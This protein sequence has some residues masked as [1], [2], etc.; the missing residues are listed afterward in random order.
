M[1]FSEPLFT[2]DQEKKRD[3]RLRLAL[4]VGV[5]DGVHAGHR[6]II[7]SSRS[8]AGRNSALVCAVT[9]DP[10]PKSLFGEAPQLLVT[11]D[12]RRRLL[13]D[14][15][16]DM[17][18]TINFTAQTAALP[19]EEFLFRL[20]SDPAF[21]LSGLCVGEHWR[22]GSR[23]R[24]NKELIKEFAS[25]YGFEFC[26]V[27]ELNDGSDIISSTLIRRLIEQGNLPRAEKLLGSRIRLCGKVV[28]GFGVAGREL[29]TPTANLDVEYGVVPPNGV[30]ACFAEIDGV[31]HPAA[32][33]IGVAPTYAVGKCRVEVHL[34]DSQA[35]LYG[36]KIG[37]EICKFIRCEQK[38]PDPGALKKQIMTDIRE[39]GAVLT[40]LR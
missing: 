15:G 8:I 32:V 1:Q 26:A 13:L 29:E 33:N 39:I 16:A 11:P 3:E 20:I 6:K 31:I 17:T 27:P 37:L 12:R 30:Y 40:A 34:L 38:F 23:G 4:A 14:A 36:R 21:E 19:P 2:F 9:F 7:E 18:A 24:G 35:D 22:F 28:H 25:R 10:H 5:F